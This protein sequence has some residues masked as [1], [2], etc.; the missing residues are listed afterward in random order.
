MRATFTSGD[1]AVRSADA[2]EDDAGDASAA[3]LFAVASA[4]TA[5]A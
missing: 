4:A 1:E 5:A 2:A 3:G